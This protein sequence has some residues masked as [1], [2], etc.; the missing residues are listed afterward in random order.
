V[1]EEAVAVVVVCDLVEM[2]LKVV[3]MRWGHADVDADDDVAGVVEDHVSMELVTDGGDAG[4]VDDGVDSD[5]L[6]VVA[7]VLFGFAH[8]HYHHY[9]YY[10]CSSAL[11]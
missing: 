4:G 10:C 8:H 3:A 7:V 1:E 6:V 11:L 9:D 5:S 2:A